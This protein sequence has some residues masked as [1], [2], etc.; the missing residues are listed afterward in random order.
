MSVNLYEIP[1][2]PVV[3]LDSDVVVYVPGY[4]KK[5]PLEPTLVTADTFKNIFGDSP[6]TFADGDNTSLSKNTMGKN[7]PDRGWLYAKGLLD[8]GLT[9][10]YHRIRKNLPKHT[11]L[12]AA[13][14]FPDRMRAICYFWLR[15]NYMQP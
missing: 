7:A 6:Y 3:D 10:L 15:H 8:A 11:M 12:S 2:T 5:G 13:H 14:G 4:A 1:I 9:V